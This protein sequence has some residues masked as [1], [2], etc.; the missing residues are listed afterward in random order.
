MASEVTGFGHET[1]PRPFGSPFAPTF[2][3]INNNSVVLSGCVEKCA[4][5]L[6]SRSATIKPQELAHLCSRLHFEPFA[7]N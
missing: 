7:L 6:R 2:E 1:I 3:S 5:A 4:F